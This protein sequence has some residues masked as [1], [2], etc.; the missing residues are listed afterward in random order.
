LRQ[1][2]FW[3]GSVIIY[4]E[5][6]VR[7]VNL[8]ER[9]AG[10]NKDLLKKVAAGLIMA[11]SLSF[12]VGIIS[13]SEVQ[14]QSRDRR[15]DRDRDNDR[16]WSRR[17]DSDRSREW[18]RRRQIELARQRERERA[19]N[20]YRYRNQRNYP[21]YGNSGRYNDYGRYN[22]GE[23][24]RGFHNGFKEGADDARDRDSFNPSRHSSFRDGNP[25]Y[26]SG[27]ARGYNQAYRQYADYRRW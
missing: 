14:A 13:P 2:T 6:S 24:Q 25:A 23:E 27:F 20:A 10:M 4:I 1:A 22:S 18:A 8:I 15:W 17:R 3:R 9:T 5:G 11:L 21:Y 12:G 7:G 26:R 16:D 19:R